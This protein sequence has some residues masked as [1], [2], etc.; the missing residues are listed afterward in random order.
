MPPTPPPIACILACPPGHTVPALVCG[1]ELFP[2]NHGGTM[3]F[4]SVQGAQG[5]LAS[6]TVSRLRRNYHCSHH[7]AMGL[8]RGFYKLKYGGCV[9]HSLP[10]ASERAPTECKGERWAVQ[11]GGCWKPATPDPDLS[12]LRL[13]GCTTSILSLTGTVGRRGGPAQFYPAPASGRQ[14]QAGNWSCP[15]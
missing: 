13:P 2:A 12:P 3:L 8:A 10:H 7:R 6:T 5:D 14:S 11:L 1:P 15:S 4:P 9:G